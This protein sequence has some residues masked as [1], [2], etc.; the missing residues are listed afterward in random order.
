MNGT[1]R[2]PGR[3]LAAGGALVLTTA[4]LV[5]GLLPG[6]GAQAASAHARVPHAVRTAADPAPITVVIDSFKPL[7]PKA[8]DELRITGR[9]VSTSSVPVS[10]VSVQLRRSSAPLSSRKQVLQATTAPLDPAGGDPDDVPLSSTRVVLA[11]TLAPGTSKAFSLRLDIERLGL[12]GPGTY[13][14]AV[15]AIGREQGVDEFDARQGVLRTFLPWYPGGTTDIDPIDLTW[16]WPLADWPARAPDGVLI[17]DRTPQELSDGGRLDTLL[18]VGRQHEDTV[19]WLADPSLL[20]TADAMSDGYQVQTAGTVVLGDHEAAARDWL[21]GVRAVATDSDLTALP[22]ADVDASALTRAGLSN[23]VVRAVTQAAPIA[24]SALGRPVTSGLYWAPFGRIDRASLD[25]LASAG[26]ST[27]ILS[28]DAVPPV[29]DEAAADGDPVASLPTAVGTIRGILR[30]PALSAVLTTPTRTASDVIV[31]RQLFLAQTSVLAQTLPN[32]APR[33]VVVGPDDVR[34]AATAS[35]VAPLL[36]ATRN[37]PWLS[38]Q[39]LTDLIDQPGGTT[40]RKRGGYGDKARAAELP[41]EYLARIARLSADLDVFTSVIDDPTGIGEP[42]SQSLLRAESAGWRSEPA[43]ADRLVT[44]ISRQLA[45]L[46]D[47][48]R[49]LSEG[50]VTLSGDTGRVPVTIVNNLDR[51]VTVGVTLIGHPSL[52]LDAAPLEGIEIDAGKMTSVDIDAKVIGGDPLDV[53]VQLLAT[54]GKPFGTPAE[55]VVSS[56]AYAR[57]AA[58]VVAASFLAIA[59]FVVFGIVR[60]IRAASSPRSSG[61]VAP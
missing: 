7:V 11:D 16:L 15:E 39:S 44:T 32:D 5:V 19:S 30:D 9:V 31:A 1:A 23:D 37:A 14:L 49:V 13:V 59:V 60:R 40:S 46:T 51:S 45:A 33:S 3:R 52:R 28:A 10:D 27:V 26:V 17:G 43:T 12:P 34:W 18:K 41:A 50:T 22:Y 25:V 4:A 24:R 53:D 48:V 6:P 21:A 42:F 2:R 58:W 35:L 36:R 47:Q 54:D 8:G 56:T 61:S 55:I 57:A 20:Q 29:G 38:S